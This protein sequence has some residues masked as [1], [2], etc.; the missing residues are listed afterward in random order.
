VHAGLISRQQ[1]AANG[2]VHVNSVKNAII[3]AT[4]KDVVNG[5]QEN[6]E[7]ELS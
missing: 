7:E 6:P 2:A 3:V 5:T 1:Y 4:E